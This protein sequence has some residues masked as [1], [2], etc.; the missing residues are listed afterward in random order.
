MPIS[1][2]NTSSNE[3]FYFITPTI[4]N[5]YYLFDRHNRWDILANSIKYCQDNK[6]LELYGGFSANIANYVHLTGRVAY[7]NFRNLYFYTNSPTD[8]SKFD[9]VYDDGITNV[10]NFY[11]EAVFNYSDELRLGLK[12]DYNKYSTASLEKAFHRPELKSTIFA[13]YNFYDKILFNSELYYIGSSYGGVRYLPAGG[14]E[15]TE[16][17]TIV[18]LNLKADYKFSNRFTVFLMGNNLLA[19]KYERFVNYP[20]KSLNLIGGVTYSF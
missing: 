7:Q 4:W 17:D 2:V 15:L 1:Q 16:T 5:W 13:T 12:T 10:L 8:A 18:D 20:V 11:A 19:K 14:K 3:G 9:L 6:G